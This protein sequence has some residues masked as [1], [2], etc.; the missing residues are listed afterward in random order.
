M[1]DMGIRATETCAFHGKSVSLGGLKNED[2][3]GMEGILGGYD[4]ATQRRIFHP[5]AS[6]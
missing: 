6:E 1:S 2:C 3:N 5:L 4:A